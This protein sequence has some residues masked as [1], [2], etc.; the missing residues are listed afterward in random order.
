VV[1]VQPPED[2]ETKTT[3][4]RKEVEK[5]FEKVPV[6]SKFNFFV[7]DSF[8]FCISFHTQLPKLQHGKK[9]LEIAKY[10]SQVEKDKTKEAQ[11]VTRYTAF[12]ED[13]FTSGVIVIKEN[14]HVTKQSGTADVSVTLP[15]SSKQT[16]HFKPQGILCAIGCGHGRDWRHKIQTAEWKPFLRA[17]KQGI[18][19][20]L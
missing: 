8:F 11:G 14:K 10:K 9:K 20:R 6:S 12:D 17:G 5:E 3:R 1:N 4:K 18:Q 19:A 7:S 13:S 2:F 16:I 15:F